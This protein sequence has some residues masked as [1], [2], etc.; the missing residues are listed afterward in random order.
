VVGELFF[1]Q[2]LTQGG[3]SWQAGFFFWHKQLYVPFEF[4]QRL[5]I[6]S[7]L[8]QIYQLLIA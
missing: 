1:I 2:I 3:C 8:S 4:S 6:S 5:S 7:G